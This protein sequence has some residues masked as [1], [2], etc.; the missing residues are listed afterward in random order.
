MALFPIALGFNAAIHPC[1]RVA[2]CA[3]VSCAVSRVVT[4]RTR[5]WAHSCCT[6]SDAPHNLLLW[7]VFISRH[8]MKYG[9]VWQT[10]PG[11]GWG[12]ANMRL[13]LGAKHYNTGNRAGYFCT[14]CNLNL[15][16]LEYRRDFRT[17]G[18]PHKGLHYA[19]FKMFIFK[20]ATVFSL[21]YEMLARCAD[22]LLGTFKSL[23]FKII[24]LQVI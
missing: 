20:P 22:F 5:S 1:S 14:N 16:E 21:T 11:I 10:V 2:I 9:K 18:T 19:L 24:K 6:S 17:L 15:L 3:E 7:R 4:L 13:R 8:C 23:N 12:A